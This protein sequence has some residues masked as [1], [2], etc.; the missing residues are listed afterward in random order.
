MVFLT[1]PFPH[2]KPY[3]PQKTSSEAL[4]LKDLLQY[5][6]M[7]LLYYAKDFTDFLNI[8]V[9]RFSAWG[10]DFSDHLRSLC[11]TCGVSAQNTSAL[12]EL[13]ER[14]THRY[15]KPAFHIQEVTSSNGKTYTVQEEVIQRKTF[16]QLIHFKKENSTNAKDVSQKIAP[17]Q[18]TILVVAPYSGHY[19]TLL[20][21]T[22]RTLLKD[23]DV[24]VTDWANGREVPLGEGIFTLDDYIQYLLDF[25]RSLQ[26]DVHILAVCQPAVPVLAAVSLMAQQNDPCQPKSM[27][28]MG[29]PIDTRV[30]PTVVNRLSQEKP[31]E[32]F[33]QN[34]IGRV[35]VYYP[36]ALRRVCPGFL[37][38][39]GF[40]SLN[41]SRHLKASLDLYTHL[42]QGDQESVE[43]HRQF[44]DEYRSVLDLPADYFLDS[45]K[46]A[47]QDH[48]LP[49]GNFFWK[50]IHVDPLAIHK[51]ALLAVE[52]EKDDISGV[53]QTH[54]A[55]DLCKNI[56][57]SMK[58]YH[59]QKG[60]GHYGVFNGR[61]FREDIV[62]AIH[63]FIRTQASGRSFKVVREA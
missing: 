30:C 51:T 3:K 62:P 36:G 19:A 41:L 23:H 54:A 8:P 1:P 55:L 33:E 15:V 39:S 11:D 14:Q 34:V 46:A 47:F 24:Y 26:G 17:H 60:V 2:S 22:C 58:A 63:K 12:F 25:I 45:V 50:G 37:M 35:P 4:F 56:P 53:G 6:E 5:Q 52:G 49:K 13:F 44:Y 18:P 43:A 29:G 7:S 48:S 38:L 32:W 57:D 20:R 21:D 28:L 40:M 27:I 10:K 61:R 42:I 16:C 31:L 59:L 9:N